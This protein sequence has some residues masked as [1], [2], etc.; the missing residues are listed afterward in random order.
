MYDFGK[1]LFDDQII[2]TQVL[3]NKIA[4]HGYIK[5]LYILYIYIFLLRT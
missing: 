1:V 4:N 5:M 3:K 2:V